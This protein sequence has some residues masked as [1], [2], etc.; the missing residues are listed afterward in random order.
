MM[1]SEQTLVANYATRD[2]D[3]RGRGIKLITYRLGDKYV[4][5][6]ESHNPGATVCRVS[7]ETIREAVETALRE[8]NERILP[9]VKGK[10][11]T[12]RATHINRIVMLI[13]GE[14]VSFHVHEFLALPLAERMQYIFSGNLTFLDPDGIQ[15]G[16]GE[17][18]EYLRAAS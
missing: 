4:C 6:I 8:A 3:V 7:R 2:L 11:P 12:G 15:I 16:A 18:M 17:A 1:M 14:E 5:I 13:N 10:T 9:A